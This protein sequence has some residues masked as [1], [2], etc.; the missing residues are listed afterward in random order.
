MFG[1]FDISFDR[2][3]RISQLHPTPHAPCDMLHS[4][5]LLTGRWLVLGIRMPW[6]IRGFCSQA[7]SS[8][9]QRSGGSRHCG[10][11]PSTARYGNFDI[12]LDRFDIILDR[13][14][15]I[16]KFYTTLHAPCAMFYLM[17]VLAGC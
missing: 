2:F 7:T 11:T 10:S 13:F 1:T 3:S 8:R 9:R 6:P 12:I 16:F 5:A 15:R 4:V 14:A 17:P